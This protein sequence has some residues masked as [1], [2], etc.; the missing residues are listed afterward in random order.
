MKGLKRWVDPACTL[1]APGGRRFQLLQASTYLL[2][3]GNPKL[4]LEQFV[5]TEWS[6]LLEQTDLLVNQLVKFTLRRDWV[7]HQGDLVC[8]MFGNRSLAEN[9]NLK[10]GLNLQ[11]GL[12]L[13]Q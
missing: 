7:G 12:T 8:S 5:G 1:H 6:A 2:N 13:G 11:D 9:L 10:N 4:E 3:L